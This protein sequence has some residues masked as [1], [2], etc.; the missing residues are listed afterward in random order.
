MRSSRGSSRLLLGLIVAAG[1]AARLG[2]AAW[3]PAA[4]SN[5]D[6]YRAIAESVADHG[7][8]GEAGRPTAER[9]PAYP[10]LLG[11]A[12]KIFG[13]TYAVILGLNL[14]C[15]AVLLVLL[16]WAGARI[17][18]E[19]VGLLAAAIAAFYPAFIYYAAQPL[20]ETMMAAA[21]A[22]AVAAFLWRPGP[23]AGAVCAAA[24]L[25]NTTFLP[26]AVVGAPLLMARLKMGRPLLYLAAFAAVYAAWPVR[27]HL[28]FDRWLLGSTAG[29]GTIFYV[30]QVVPQ[31]LGGTQAEVDI[32]ANDPVIQG[33][34]AIPDV[35]DREKHMWRAGLAK[36]AENPAAFFRRFAW[37][38]LWDQWRLVPRPRNYEQSYELLWWA[39]AL[40][41]GWLIP[42]GLAGLVLWRG[43]PRE[44]AVPA[45][46]VLCAAG[47]YA[48]IL[49]ILRYRVSL[50]PW[51]ILF[52]AYALLRLRK[53][54]VAAGL[55]FLLAAPAVDAAAA[56][57][58][59]VWLPPAD[60][61]VFAPM[62]AEM[63]R[64]LERLKQDAFGP[65]YFLAY[66]LTRIL[67]WETQAYFGAGTGGG[68]DD[69]RVLYV[70]ARFGDRKLDN[71]DLSYHGW[72]GYAPDDPEALRQSLWALTDGAY[73][74][75][76]AGFL[77]KKARRATEY[78]PEPLD[79]FS[80]EPSTSATRANP[81]YE[82]EKPALEAMVRRLSAVFKK[83]P[84][85]FEAQASLSVK[86]TRRYLL[87]SEGA[88]LATPAEHLPSSLR[89][90]AM[91]RADDGMRLDGH[92]TWALRDLKDLPP[93]AELAAAAEKLAGEVTA[94]RQA[95]LQA[96]AAGPAIL[97]PE[98][99]GVLFHEALGHKLEGQRQRDPRQ[100][101]IFRDQIGRAI[102][103]SFISVSD[104][105][106]LESFKGKRLGGHY[107]FDSE[108]VPARRVAL[109]ERGVLR[110]FLLS[111]WPVKGFARS[112]GHGRS[113][114]Y[115][116]PSGRMANLIVEAHSSVPKEELVRRLMA[117]ARKQG[118]PYGFYLAGSFG[119]ENPN[120][121]E[122]AQTLEVRPRLIYRVDA[123]TGERTLVR[124]VKV[125]G[126]PL[127]FLNRIVAA[128]DDAEAAHGFVCGA[129]SG[130]V[131]V[132]QVAPSVLVS[133]V[134]L[135]RL[136]EDR[137]RPPILPS[138]LHER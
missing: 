100:S 102:L 40:S 126:T 106:T 62:Q 105:P 58:P 124:G 12:F 74:S 61:E 103:P 136:P 133:E 36:A 1:L 13:K 66:R 123:K 64:S 11:L 69:L 88:R 15:S 16:Y 38:L 81:P 50:M 37:R 39:S 21:G 108:G 98:F 42:L 18:G 43:R 8:L 85:V 44:G 104:D 46:F 54:L 130:Y 25:V 31:E 99:T 121:R 83:Y 63:R 129:E 45:V 128:A 111:R 53:K 86:W 26:F 3:R 132:S 135:Q 97:D 49:S 134:E 70:E 20:R 33:A 82:S 101:Q 90:S 131:P 27:N 95:P 4:A 30:Y 112:N 19:D 125:V 57:R 122:A 107:E 127:V 84:K 60:E 114:P 89:F 94:L 22:A 24:S 10:V 7:V 115:R 96:P 117:L 93:E 48:L 56:P 35:I 55:L 5:Q 113:D 52:A 67:R 119:G 120:Y 65:P 2:Y 51:V 76:V 17:F 23:V 28:V 78:V 77:E 68:D 80:I 75:A 47:A 116:H 110:E 41:D 32:V 118:K 14:L 138:P 137:S 34:K 6:N 91:T 87:T 92:R 59:D 71:T 72:Q 29:A 9:E 109:V 79:D 73:K